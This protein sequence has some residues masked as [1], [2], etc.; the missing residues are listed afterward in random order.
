MTTHLQKAEALAGLIF[1]ET[2]GLRQ[3]PL[4]EAGL[5]SWLSLFRLSRVFRDDRGDPL[6]EISTIDPHIFEVILFGSVARGT[7]NPG[8]IDLVLLDNGHFSNFIP[9]VDGTLPD[10]EKPAGDMYHT[11][12]GNL[13][14]L[15]EAWFGIGEPTLVE[16]LGDT[17]VD[18]HV[19]PLDLLTSL[20]IR[21]TIAS[22][23]D[24][25]RFFQN[26]FRD[27]RRFNRS[28]GQFEP[29]SLEELEAQYH[30]DLSDLR[31]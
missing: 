7:E 23:H 22:K 24:D 3:R 27:A 14:W 5:G 15:M 6:K 21:T 19:L 9:G 28:S 16:L 26:I 8:D 1:A 25:P 13:A 11:L 12:R 4:R 18:L 20:E 17:E 2:D 10:G 29:V 30:C 31:S